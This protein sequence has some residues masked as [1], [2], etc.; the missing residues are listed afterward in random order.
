MDLLQLGK[1]N[2]Y[3]KS[4]SIDR[5]FG[6]LP[7]AQNIDLLGV[8]T[9]SRRGS[10]LFPSQLCEIQSIVNIGEPIQGCW[11]G[12]KFWLAGLAGVVGLGALVRLVGC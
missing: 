1:E 9:T 8:Q 2:A 7:R 11:F 5:D 4:I 3:T 10:F 12:C 6:L